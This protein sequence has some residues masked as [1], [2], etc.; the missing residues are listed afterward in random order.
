MAWKTNL[1]LFLSFFLIAGSSLFLDGKNLVGKKAT[2]IFDFT[3]QNENQSNKSYFI[4]GLD[5]DGICKKLN[6]NKP[7]TG[8]S[9]S[10]VNFLVEFRKK[11]NEMRENRWI[12]KKGYI[13]E[14]YVFF[15][16]GKTAKINIKEER[17][18]TRIAA[19]ISV[20]KK[21]IGKIMDEKKPPEYDMKSF[22]YTLTKTRAVLSIS[23]DFEGNK[24]NL[25]KIELITGPTEHLFLSVDLP[26]SKISVAKFLGDNGTI[27]PKETPKEFYIGFNC[28]IGDILSEKQCVLKN[29]FFKGMLKLSK[30]PLDSYGV[31]IGYRFPRIRFLGINLSSFSMFASLIWTKEE[32]E[33]NNSDTLTKRQVLFGFSYNLDKALEWMK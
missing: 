14:I 19:D 28:M 18:K 8:D 22:S 17:R 24:G 15:M 5:I 10:I 12:S 27:E 31:G 9:K 21:I 6:V 26:V 11:Y 30:K 4:R 1:I 23:V 16:G 32:N 33:E 13:L 25:K 29:L 3:I 2:L 7:E 20:L